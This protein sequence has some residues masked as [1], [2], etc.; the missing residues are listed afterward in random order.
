MESELE[1][2]E[3]TCRLQVSRQFFKTNQSSCSNWLSRLYLPMMAVAYTNHNFA[4]VVR[5]GGCSLRD[6]KKRFIEKRKKD[7]ADEQGLLFSKC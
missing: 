7:G 1:L 4:Q 3:H 6:I 5:L 2:T